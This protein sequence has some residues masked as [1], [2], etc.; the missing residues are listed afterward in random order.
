[1]ELINM[2]KIIFYMGWVILSLVALVFAAEV[3]I[4]D[5]KVIPEISEITDTYK[6][7][8]DDIVMYENV[9]KDNLNYKIISE[10]MFIGYEKVY[11][12]IT[13]KY[14][15]CTIDEKTFE[16][17]CVVKE[18]NV[19]IIDERQRGKPIY[20]KIRDE[21]M[22]FDNGL[23]VDLIAQ[24]C[25]ICNNT[26]VA[27]LGNQDGGTGVSHRADEFKC[28]KDGYPIIRSGETGTIKSIIEKEII[29]KLIK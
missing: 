3:I 14:E 11:K 12:T 5:D 13:E 18:H 4:I 21:S 28:D 17:V 26:W 19:S 25:W 1:M 16:E 27:C 10:K 29:G 2:K 8:G 20:R 9:T 23:N 6:Q 22:V 15:N 24:S 7:I